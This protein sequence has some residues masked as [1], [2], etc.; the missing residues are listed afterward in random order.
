[1]PP[2]LYALL[3]CTAA[4]MLL[5]VGAALRPVFDSPAPPPTM[6]SFGEI[7]FAQDMAVHHAQARSIAASL[8]PT[9]SSEVKSLAQQIEAS[10]SIEI[11]ILHGWLMLLD[12]P[13]ASDSPMQWMSHADSHSHTGEENS[14]MPGLASWDEINALSTLTGD[15]AEIRFLQLMIRHHRG[16]I[17]MATAGAAMATSDAV[18]RAARSMADEQTKDLGYMTLLLEQRSAAALPYP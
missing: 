3:I 2:R 16:G 8:S 10:Q 15:D 17:E 14:P 12:Q 6:L 4:C 13:L 9:A 7:G 11:G 5:V 18:A 1:M